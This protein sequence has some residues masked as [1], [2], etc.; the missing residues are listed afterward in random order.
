MAY[1][2]DD[3]KISYL[4]RRR[5]IAVLECI[6]VL[7]PGIDA[8]KKKRIANKILSICDGRDRRVK[9]SPAQAQQLVMGHFQC[10][11]QDC[12]LLIFA[13]PLSRELNEFF[14]GE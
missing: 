9:I 10:L 14:E 1:K 6:D 8:R 11:S 4:A 13:E 3:T 7:L 12:P 5:V 2:R